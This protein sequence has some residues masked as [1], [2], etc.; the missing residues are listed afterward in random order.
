MRCTLL[1]T[2]ILFA[3]SSTAPIANDPDQGAIEAAVLDT[4][5]SI[6]G[7]AGS[8]DWVHLTDLFAPGARLMVMRKDGVGVMTLDEYIA[9]AKPYFEK[10]GF[11]E[12]PASNRVEHFRDIAHVFSVYESR[13]AATDAEPFARGTNSFQ[14][15]RIGGRWR[16]Q[17]ILWQEAE[18]PL[19]R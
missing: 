8:R 18:T 19:S 4:Y 7:P 17:S 3:C 15:V 11:F 14:L 9:R 5:N 13:H 10:N 16:V 12:K 2:A 6:S 1:L